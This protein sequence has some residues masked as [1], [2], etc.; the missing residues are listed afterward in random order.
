[1]RLDSAMRSIGD[2]GDG[3]EPE[4]HDDSADL[5]QSLLR[6]GAPDEERGDGEERGG[7]EGERRAERGGGDKD[8]EAAIPPGNLAVPAL[9]EQ[10]DEH[11]RD[12]R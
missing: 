8:G 12:P 1:M 5:K 7:S 6:T 11:R 4:R 2:D 3:G 10:D 9:H